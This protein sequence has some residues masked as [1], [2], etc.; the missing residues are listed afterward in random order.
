MNRLAAILVLALSTPCFAQGDSTVKPR[1]QHLCWRGKPA[2][3]C[4]SFWVTE[5]GFDGMV[6]RSQTRVVQDVG[7]GSESSY[8]TPDFA[9]HLAWTVGPMFNTSPDRA[10]GF[11]LSLAPVN[12]DSRIAAEARRRWWTSEGS[13]VD[14]SA[15]LVTM[16]VPQSTAYVSSTAYGMTVGAYLVGGDLINVN[17]RTDVLFSGGR[18][19]VGASLGVGLDSYAAVGGT[20]ILGAL[21][22]LILAS[23]GGI[24]D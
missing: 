4:T 17:G 14:L 12:G 20:V 24:G 22:V 16:N 1:R 5:F 7:T 10:I 9:S 3:T 21:V 2:P 13:A 18:T 8:T 11:T 15:G 23:W 19:R 6:A